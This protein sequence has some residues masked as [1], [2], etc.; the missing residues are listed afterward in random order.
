MTNLKRKV[1]EASSRQSSYA[2]ALPEQKYKLLERAFERC[3]PA[4]YSQTEKTGVQ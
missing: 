3:K 1:C 2:Y 4:N